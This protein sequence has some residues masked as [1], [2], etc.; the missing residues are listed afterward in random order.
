MVGNHPQDDLLIVI[1]LA[2]YAQKFKKG[3]PENAERALLLAD[4]I[5]GQHGLTPAECVLQL[6]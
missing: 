4:R 2:L 6:E 1:G 5:S 3:E